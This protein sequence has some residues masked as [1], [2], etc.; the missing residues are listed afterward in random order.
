MWQNIFF[1][2]KLLSDYPNYLYKG[3]DDGTEVTTNKKIS[4]PGI[5][6]LI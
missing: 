4:P 1:N 5:K 2:S 6:A 3:D